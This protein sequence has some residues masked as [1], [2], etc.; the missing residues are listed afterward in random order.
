MRN[1]R[2]FAAAYIFIVAVCSS[3]SASAISVDVVTDAT[4]LANNII[5]PGITL[6][7]TPTLTGATGQAGTYT[8][9][10]GPADGVVLSTGDVASIPGTP[11]DNV[12]TSYGGAGDADVSAIPASPFFVAPGVT[13]DAVALEFNILSGPGASISYFLATD[14]MPD[15][16][17]TGTPPSLNSA[18]DIAA[19]AWNDGALILVD[20]VDI[21]IDAADNPLTSLRI[22]HDAVP[23]NPLGFGPISDTGFSEHSGPLVSAFETFFL[24]P[25]THSI[26]IVVADGGDDSFQD[27]ALF[28]PNGALNAVV[29]IPPA[30]WLF[31][32][33]L[34]GLVGIARRKKAT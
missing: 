22:Q 30:V 32:S 3:S 6:V 16:L 21:T 28:I 8:G 31:V 27:T 1:S 24:T 23:F 26:K 18:D 7:G 13:A 33:G 5:G 29:P 11:A 19:H 14:D 20:G 15:L 25:G 10:A 34:L 9:A 4:T 12:S 17:S 2:L